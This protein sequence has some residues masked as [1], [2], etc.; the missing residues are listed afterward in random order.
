MSEDQLI[1]FL[2]AVK[3]DAGLQERLKIAKDADA[4]VAIAQA[5]GF[6]ISAN[7]LMKAQAELSDEELEGVAGGVGCARIYGI[8]VDQV[9][10]AASGPI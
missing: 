3:A 9:G 4:V 10:R 6:V 8:D 7:D 1:A 5:A 2:E